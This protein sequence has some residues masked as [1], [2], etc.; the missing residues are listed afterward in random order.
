MQDTVALSYRIS[1]VST[2]S[3]GPYPTTPSIALESLVS[4][5]PY[6]RPNHCK[7]L[8]LM[9]KM[10][11][12]GELCQSEGWILKSGDQTTTDQTN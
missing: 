4:L 12:H 1:K 8:K 10:E 6:I 3:C 5:D 7:G 2:G 9:I 11:L